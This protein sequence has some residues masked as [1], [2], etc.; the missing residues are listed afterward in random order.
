MDRYLLTA[1]IRADG[2]SRFPVQNRWGYYPS[3]GAG[4]II[5]KESFMLNQKIFETLKLR[6]SWGKVGNDNIPTDA[7]IVTVT[8]NLPYPFTAG[9][10]TPG[11]AITRIKDPNLKWE[12]TTE[13]DLALEFSL[14]QNK[15]TGE[16]GYY[17]KKITDALI[18]VK[19]PAVA[20]DQFGLVLTN[21]A[22]ILNRGL[23]L[24]LLWSEKINDNIS[25]HIGGNI[26]LN[27]NKVVGLN[28]GQPIVDGGVASQQFTTKTDNGQPVGSFYVLK[29][30]GVFQSEAEVANYRNV[31]GTLIQ[32]A[33]HAGDLK[34]EKAPLPNKQ[35][36]TGPIDLVKDR[37][38]AG[39]YQPKAYYGINGGISYKNFDFSIDCYGN[40]GNQVY[41]GKKAFRLSNGAIDNVESYQAYARWTASNRSQ[42]EPAA[43][44]GNLPASTYFI[45]SGSFIRIN[46][47][48]LGYTLPSEVLQRIKI[49]SV[50]I[51]ATS[52]NPYI[53]KKYSGFTPELPGTPTASGIE[54]NAYPTTKTFALGINVGF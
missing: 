27:K 22:A 3:V 52:Q 50:R 23:E 25:Y 1:T 33:A 29:M 34:Y 28:G 38:F 5:S 13:S 7:F 9:T 10:A 39:S 45:E 35:N 18:N 30:I 24:S 19:I 14:L 31:D 32:P 36:P 6:G 48:T 43:N 54:T 21:A 46:N 42:S 17:D 44:G 37:Q 12:T 51:Y 11:S 8:Q 26:T 41:N 16:I 20:G 15:L 40:T 49:S 47:V 4:W 53:Y 2:S